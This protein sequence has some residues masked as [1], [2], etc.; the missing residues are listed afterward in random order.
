MSVKEKMS[1]KRGIRM[2]PSTLEKLEKL[3]EILLD[4]KSQNKILE[5]LINEKYKEVKRIIKEA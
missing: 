3:N 1:I 2:K 5:E 4:G